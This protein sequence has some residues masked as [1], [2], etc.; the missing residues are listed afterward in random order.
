MTIFVRKK[1]TYHASY[2]CMAVT[3][4]KNFSEVFLVIVF[5][6]MR[7]PNFS[8]K[9]YANGVFSEIRTMFYC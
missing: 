6:E 1:V 8:S 2:L 7:D 5:L 4:G 3:H 9:T